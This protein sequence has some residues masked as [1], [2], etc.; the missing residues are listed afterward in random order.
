M[1]YTF[2]IYLYQTNKIKFMLTFIIFVTIAAAVIL[3]SAMKTGRVKDENKNYV[4]DVLE[5][6]VETPKEEVVSDVRKVVTSVE[7]KVKKSKNQPVKN[8]PAKK[9]VKNK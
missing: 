9:T 1:F 7:P 8:Q 3:Y 2:C 6:K 4:P 5:P